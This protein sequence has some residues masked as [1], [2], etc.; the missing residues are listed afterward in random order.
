MTPL[1]LLSIMLPIYG[2]CCLW[3]KKIMGIWINHYTIFTFITIGSLFLYFKHP[4]VKV[5]DETLNVFI[6]GL[7]FYDITIFFFKKHHFNNILRKD[8][9]PISIPYRILIVTIILL[10]PFYLT[11]RNQLQSGLELWQIRATRGEV[12]NAND[13]MIYLYA[14]SPFVMIL[15]VLSFYQLFENVSKYLSRNQLLIGTVLIITI[16]GLIDGGGRTGLMTFF[17]VYILAVVFNKTEWRIILNTNAQFKWYI[18]AIPLLVIVLMTSLRGISSG[19]TSFIDAVSNSYTMHI[20]LFDWYYQGNWFEFHPQTWGLSTFESPIL[21]LNR[22]SK[23]CIGQEIPYES[24]DSTIQKFRYVGNGLSYNA[25]STMYFRFIRD[26]GML[27]IV[28][29][30]MLVS[31]C[32]TTLYKA[33]IRNKFYFLIYLYSLSIVCQLHNELIFSKVSF[34]LFILYMIIIKYLFCKRRR[35]I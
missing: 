29:G 8:W 20:L 2:I 6:W 4:P 14:I 33:S 21:F 31:T 16:I 19:E 26:W 5:S 15:T 27:G 25:C 17:F 12:R 13:G 10:V 7:F 1:I 34:L 18:M 28:I 23:I 22:L 11:L 30:P 9:L 35:E 32:L 3:S 24:V